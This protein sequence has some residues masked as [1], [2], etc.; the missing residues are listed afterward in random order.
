MGSHY[1]WACVSQVVCQI[2]ES[3]LIATLA[4][5]ARL[6]D[7][8]TVECQYPEDTQHIRAAAESICE[9]LVSQVIVRECDSTR[10]V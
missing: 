6:C 4:A 7:R 1:W 8:A 10:L 2:T 9:E 3:R 5:Q